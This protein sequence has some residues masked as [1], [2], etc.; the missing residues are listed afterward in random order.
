MSSQDTTPAE[1]VKQPVGIGQ[2]IKTCLLP[3]ALIITALVG[4]AYAVALFA[5]NIEVIRQFCSD[6]VEVISQ[7][8]MLPVE[9]LNTVLALKY[10]AI[11]LFISA[12]CV[13]GQYEKASNRSI[14]I[15]FLVLAGS[16]Y[17]FMLFLFAHNYWGIDT[18]ST[19]QTILSV[20]SCLP[21]IILVFLSLIFITEKL[22]N[23]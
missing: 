3:S 6:N 9:S 15:A 2:A 5:D 16:F 23:A 14:W 8:L 7:F 13:C 18:L 11:T 17:G 4:L 19:F 20:V 21:A 12:A 10:V 1:G 22:H